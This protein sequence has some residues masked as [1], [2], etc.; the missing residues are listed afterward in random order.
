M[1]MR[2]SV[3][4]VLAGI[5]LLPA[6]AIAGPYT[7][8]V[9]FGDSLSDVGNDAIVTPQLSAFGI[10]PT[11]GPYY[12]NGRFSNGQNYVDDLSTALGLPAPKPSL[13]GGTDYAYGD[14]RTSGSSSVQRLVIYDVDQQVSSYLS[15]ST[16][17][18][19]ALYDIFAGANDLIASPTPTTATTAASNIATDVSTLYAAGA[20]QFL[21]PNLPLLGLT[22]E[23]NTNPTAAASANALTVVFNTALAA[24]LAGLQATDPG[25]T[26]HELDVQTLFTGVVTS[27]SSYGLVDVADSAAPGLEPGATSYDT[28]LE[29]SDPN[30]YLFWDDIH[31]TAAGH[32]LLANAAGEAVGV[33]EPTSMGLLAVSGLTLI[34]RR[35]RH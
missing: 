20:R 14:A 21:V 32:A 2:K 33:P 6:A 25:I 17:S 4:T 27:P 35:R 8:L 30:Q 19:G 24:D 9:V 23:F 3:L 10:T 26:I 16:P 29:V 18:A 22:P 12:Y 31:A 28:S 13:A 11:P 7:G 1:K 5:G 34:Q 15:T